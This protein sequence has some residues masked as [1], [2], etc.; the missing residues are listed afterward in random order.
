M[1]T[2]VQNTN[3]ISMDVFGKALLDYQSGEYTEDII[4]NSSLNDEDSMPLPY[5]FRTYIEMPK[6]EQKALQ[7][8]KGKVLD[9][10]CGAGSHSIYLQQ[11]GFNVTGIDRSKGAIKVCKQRG[12]ENA[13]CND[14]FDFKEQQYHTLLLLMNGLGIVGSLNGLHHF[15]SHLASLLLPG[16]QIL[17]DSSDIIYMFEEDADGGRWIPNNGKYYGEV[18]F[19]MSYKNKKSETFSW[20]YADQ[21]TLKNAAE[22]AEL[23]CE[24]VSLGDHFDYLARLTPRKY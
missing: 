19:S 7:L 22:S 21:K 15:L 11:Q 23:N 4:T 3:Y 17:L 13:I 1:T 10:G 24:I 6:L 9:I 14:I 20:L 8:C 2:F 18:E 16:G 5:L 12:L